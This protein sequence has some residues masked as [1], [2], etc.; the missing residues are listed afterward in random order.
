MS[1]NRYL[2]TWRRKTK[3]VAKSNCN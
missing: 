1:L 2:S 3:K